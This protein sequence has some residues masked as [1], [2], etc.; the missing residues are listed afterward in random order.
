[1]DLNENLVKLWTKRA[2][3]YYEAA[4]LAVG[5]LQDRHSV[6]ADVYRIC[7]EE[8]MHPPT[9]LLERLNNE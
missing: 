3:A 8:L 1:M 7:A 4:A 6:T 9:E 2:D 5:V